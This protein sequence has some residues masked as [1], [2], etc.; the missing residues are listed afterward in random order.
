MERVDFSQMNKVGEVEGNHILECGGLVYCKGYGFDCIMRGIR[1][2]YWVGIPGG[3]H[4]FVTF[5]NSVNFDFDKSLWKSGAGEHSTVLE[6]YMK[7]AHVTGRIQYDPDCTVTQV[8]DLRKI[9]QKE[10]Q[11]I[12]YI[13]SAHEQI[14]DFVEK[15]MAEQGMKKPEK[16]PTSYFFFKERP[17]ADIMSL[18][19]SIN[20]DIF[21]VLRSIRR[22]IM[23]KIHHNH[24]LLRRKN[25]KNEPLVI[26]GEYLMFYH[27]PTCQAY[28]PNKFIDE[29]D[30]TKTMQ[31]Y[32]RDHKEHESLGRYLAFPAKK[33]KTAESSEDTYNKWQKK[34]A[35]S[36]FNEVFIKKNEQNL[37]TRVG[38]EV[39]DVSSIK[40]PFFTQWFKNTSCTTGYVLPLLQ[41]SSLNLSYNGQDTVLLCGTSNGQLIENVLVSIRTSPP[42]NF[43]VEFVFISQENFLWFV[44]N[45]VHALFGAWNTRKESDTG[46]SVHTG[47]NVLFKITLEKSTPRNCNRYFQIVV[48]EELRIREG[49]SIQELCVYSSVENEFLLQC[50]RHKQIYRKSAGKTTHAITSSIND[51]IAKNT[52][53]DDSEWRPGQTQVQG[54]FYHISIKSELGPVL[55]GKHWDKS[56]AEAR[57]EFL[58]KTIFKPKDQYLARIGIE[59]KPFL[60]RRYDLYFHYPPVWEKGEGVFFTHTAIRKET[61]DQVFSSMLKDLKHLES[62][63][64]AKPFENV[65]DELF[66]KTIDS[67]IFREDNSIVYSKAQFEIFMEQFQE[68]IRNR[69]KGDTANEENVKKPRDPK[70]CKTADGDIIS[71]N[72][73][74]KCRQAHKN[75]VRDWLRTKSDVGPL[76]PY[77]KLGVKYV[78][79]LGVVSDPCLEHILVSSA[80]C[81][82]LT[83]NIFVFCREDFLHLVEALR[84]LLGDYQLRRDCRWRVK[85]GLK[86]HVS[87]CL[88]DLILDCNTYIVK[89]RLQFGDIRQLR[90]FSSTKYDVLLP[91]KDNFIYFIARM[92]NRP[93]SFGAQTDNAGNTFFS[94]VELCNGYKNLTSENITQNDIVEKLSN[95]FEVT[96]VDTTKIQITRKQKQL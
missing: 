51:G 22:I 64:H 36:C 16:H 21:S 67:V 84:I 20:G 17:P 49:H 93:R 35:F 58:A 15:L 4:P 39:V 73:D 43:K 68:T 13:A 53:V 61:P 63:L 87:T 3:P 69:K 11:N 82:T 72:K 7:S 9:D 40:L 57:D 6:K 71:A 30:S 50:M 78:T 60:V 55:G 88:E 47:K 42:T 1:K 19:M 38:H 92:H 81:G 96:T 70:M 86:H 94:L 29:M 32:F 79:P 34:W 56:C 77:R 48:N 31:R 62:Y 44:E 10:L 12:R 46:Y 75:F 54:F 2:D 80:C 52:T 90:V 45:V 83:M 8:V 76:N 41:F 95:W 85:C 5:E 66:I 24:P 65:M 27:E 26:N 28:K 18:L 14:C 25:I 37:L 59:L 91:E 89:D 74:I 33:G 23:D